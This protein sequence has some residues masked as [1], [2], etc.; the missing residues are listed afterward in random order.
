MSNAD[1]VTLVL[2][3]AAIAISMCTMDRQARSALE[4]ANTAERQ[5]GYCQEDLTTC[6]REQ[7]TCMGR[8]RHEAETLTVYPSTWGCRQLPDLRWECRPVKP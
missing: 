8:W 5:E 6:R 2:A 1:R 7:Q 4:R 3:I